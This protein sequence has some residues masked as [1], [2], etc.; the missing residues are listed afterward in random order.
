[1]TAQQIKTLNR[2]FRSEST[3]LNYILAVALCELETS[4]NE[5][6]ERMRSEY[7][8]CFFHYMENLTD[9]S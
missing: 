7:G 5:E 9:E 1:M 6:P 2:L 8:N 4:I 3:Q